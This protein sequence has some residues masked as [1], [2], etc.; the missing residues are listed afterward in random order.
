MKFFIAALALVAV[1]VNAQVDIPLSWQVECSQ[2]A[3]LTE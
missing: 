1:G 2:D 3:R